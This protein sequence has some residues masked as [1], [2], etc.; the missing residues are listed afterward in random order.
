MKADADHIHYE[1]HLW[2]G[3]STRSERYHTLTEATNALAVAR[4]AMG[5]YS[6][7]EVRRVMVDIV[8]VVDGE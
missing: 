8:R 5:W 4:K 6:R 2:Y 7:L 3:R 1:L